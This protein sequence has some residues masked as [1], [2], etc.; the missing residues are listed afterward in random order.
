MS[1]AE[2]REGEPA[3][4]RAVI[5]PAPLTLDPRAVVATAGDADG[6]AHVTARPMELE[7]SEPVSPWRPELDVST[8]SAGTRRRLRAPTL[9]ELDA[10]RGGED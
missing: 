7:E 6:A 1:A 10:G 3:R 5:R 9:E 4:R 2:K 8:F